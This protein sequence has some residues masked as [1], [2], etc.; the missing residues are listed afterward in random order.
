MADESVLRVTPSLAIPLE[1]LEWRFSASGGPGG[2]HANTSNTRAEVRFDVAHSPSLDDDVRATLLE[3]FGPSI[4]IVASDQ[5]SQAQNRELAMQRLS[6]RLASALTRPSPRR[7][8]RPSLASQRRRLE[9]KRHRAAL[10]RQ[11]RD[12][13]AGEID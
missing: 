7:P 10:K 1:E 9:W 11:R 2:Q 6:G 13:G 12:R 8:T 3:R 4:R 5:R